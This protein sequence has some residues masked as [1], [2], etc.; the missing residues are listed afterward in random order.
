[1]G[2]HITGY[3]GSPGISIGFCFLHHRRDE[4]AT[5]V[6]NVVQD[7]LYADICATVPSTCVNTRHGGEPN[8]RQ[9]LCD[10]LRCQPS[11]GVAAC[12]LAV[13]RA[14]DSVTVG[15]VGDA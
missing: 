14:A 1:M 3:N 13:Q 7:V 15:V 9:L 5:G 12:I 4:A 10:A 8:A 2:H 6:P 11:K